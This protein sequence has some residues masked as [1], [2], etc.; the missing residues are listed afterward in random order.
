MTCSSKYFVNLKRKSD[1]IK[2]SQLLIICNNFDKFNKLFDRFL[3]FKRTLDHL[4]KLTRR[5][6]QHGNF[7]M[8][9]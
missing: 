1:K 5:F 3:Y 9:N 8:S 6:T 2:F 7:L 4:K